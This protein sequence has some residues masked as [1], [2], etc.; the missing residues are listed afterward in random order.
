MLKVLRGSQPRTVKTRNN[1]RVYSMAL[2]RHFSLRF[3]ITTFFILI[4][5]RK[6]LSLEKIGKQKGEILEHFH[7]R[8]SLRGGEEYL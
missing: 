3:Y 6:F 5:I 1:Y 4:I 7:S 2:A 8:A